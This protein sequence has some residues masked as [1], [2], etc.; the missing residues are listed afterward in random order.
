MYK[1]YKIKKRKKIFSP[2]YIF[3]IFAIA[4]LFV[5]SGY[6]MLS[7]NL[8]IVG[9]ANISTDAKI[10]G[11]STYTW[12]LFTT[13]P[14]NDGG[15][16]YQIEMP[17][18][19]LDGDID[20]WEVS[21]DVPDNCIVSISNIWQASEVTISGNTITLVG[22]GW[23]G[24]LSNGSVLPLN[25]IIPFSTTDVNFDVTNVMLNGKYIN[26]IPQN[27]DENEDDNTN[28]N[29]NNTGNDNTT[30]NENNTGNDNTTDNEDIVDTENNTTTEGEN[31]IEN[32][33]TTET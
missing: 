19:N 27:N 10:Y 6:A 22:Q 4:V 29:E 31:I 7:D 9:K 16:T 33:N 17:I 18:T 2:Y 32:E 28:D 14:N 1:K 11:K 15:M 24:Y 8:S 30:D 21:F 23:N 26:F 3:I 5:T 12:S 25:L 13:F 20:L